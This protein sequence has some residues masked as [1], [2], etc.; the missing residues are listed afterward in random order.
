MLKYCDRCKWD[1]DTCSKSIP[2]GMTADDLDK[3]PD[4]GAPLYEAASRD[5]IP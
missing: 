2:D 5:D 1:E 4:C 3:C